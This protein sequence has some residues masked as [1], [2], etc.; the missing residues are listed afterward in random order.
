MTEKF[1]TV[2]ATAERLSLAPYT[3]RHWLKAGKLRGVKMGSGLGRHVWRIP[4]SAIAEFVETFPTNEVG[5]PTG[6]G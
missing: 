1:L 2:N 4:E 6:A 5:T 3:V